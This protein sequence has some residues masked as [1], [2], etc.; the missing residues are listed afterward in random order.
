MLVQEEE[1]EEGEEE[2][3]EREIG[4]DEKFPRRGLIVARCISPER[5]KN[6]P[7]RPEDESENNPPTSVA[8]GK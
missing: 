1:E 7:K 8:E 2:E 3:E 4:I 6:T 5:E